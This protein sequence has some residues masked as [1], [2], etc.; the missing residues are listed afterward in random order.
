MSAVG[1]GSGHIAQAQKRDGYIAGSQL[2]KCFQMLEGLGRKV[3][4]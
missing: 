2:L 3:A 4:V 1:C